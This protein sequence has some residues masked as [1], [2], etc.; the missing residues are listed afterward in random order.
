MRKII[1][2]PRKR[3]RD[4]EKNR[5]HQRDHYWRRKAGLGVS[6]CGIVYNAC[7][8]EF[9]KFWGRLDPAEQD[10][11]RA[12]AAAISRFVI[13]TAEYDKALRP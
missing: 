5:K 11:P 4:P 9:L 10:D 6:R 1:G 12:I 3:R 8:I 2:S 7:V 13:E